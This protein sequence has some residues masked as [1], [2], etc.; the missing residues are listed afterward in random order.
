MALVENRRE[1]RECKTRKKCAKD[2]VLDSYNHNKPSTAQYG[3]CNCGKFKGWCGM[4]KSHIP[5]N[6]GCKK[7]GCQII[8]MLNKETINR[9]RPTNRKILSLLRYR[10][11]FFNEICRIIPQRTEVALSL[12]YLE[13]K[14]TI[15]SALEQSSFETDKRWVRTYRIVKRRR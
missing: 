12:I 3:S 11:R 10:P 2:I 15:K 4:P 5:E 6:V 8:N 14:G 13:E 7:C 1:C 9:L